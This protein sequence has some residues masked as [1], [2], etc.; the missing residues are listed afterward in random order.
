MA[1]RLGIPVGCCSVEL[2]VVQNGE[3][4][5]NN[6]S[7]SPVTERLVVQLGI[8][9]ANAVAGGPCAADHVLR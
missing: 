7:F 3:G 4:L 6:M 8:T 9:D 1:G 2:Q 5:L